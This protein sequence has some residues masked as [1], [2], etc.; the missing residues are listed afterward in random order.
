MNDFV[1]WLITDDDLTL[2]AGGEPLLIYDLDCITQDIKHMIR[3]SGLLVQVVGQRS[4]DA[5]ADL[6][7][8]LVLLV[9]TDERLV[10]GTVAITRQSSA[11]F[12]VT[13]DTY[14]YGPTTLQVTTNG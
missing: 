13:A 9:E 10:P 11:L 12:F 5:V 1:D 7:L 3:D 2:D 4:D 6:L 14:L 8:Q